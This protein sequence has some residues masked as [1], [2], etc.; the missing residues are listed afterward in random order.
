MK[1]RKIICL[2]VML[3]IIAIPIAEANLIEKTQKLYTFSIPQTLES[4]SKCNIKSSGTIEKQVNLA[5]IKLGNNGFVFFLKI[6]YENDGNTT[7]YC[8]QTGEELW[9]HKGAHTIT[10]L[11]YRGKFQYIFNQ[12]PGNGI[13]LNGKAFRISYEII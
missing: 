12:F 2:Y 6:T 3:V 4:Y 13:T 7:I 9:H 8:T 5:L 10:L 1:N 11:L